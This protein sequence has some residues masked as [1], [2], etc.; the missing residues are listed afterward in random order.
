MILKKLR[1]I[2]IRCP[3]LN[4]KKKLTKY[5]NNNFSHLKEQY[6]NFSESNALS[7]KSYQRYS[8]TDNTNIVYYYIYNQKINIIKYKPSFCNELLTVS[9]FINKE[10]PKVLY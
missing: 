2:S 1:R 5:I 4:D 7:D 8:K 10:Y 3:A 6:N 9:E